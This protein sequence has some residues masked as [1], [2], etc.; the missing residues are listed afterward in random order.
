[1]ERRR[2]F[3][4]RCTRCVMP[5]KYPDISFNSEGVC[6]YC[7][8]EQHFGV[9]GDPE[10]RELMARKNELR[11]DFERA[12]SECKGQG[13]YDCLV[14]L[15]GGKDS[16]YLAYLLKERYE[17]KILSLTVDTGLL[18]KLAIPNCQKTAEY[19]DIDH[20]VITPRAGFFKKLYR[21][22]LTHPNFVKEKYEEVGYL[23]TVCRACCEAVHSIGLQEAYRRGIPLVALGYSPDQIEHYFYEIPRKEICEQ[24]WVPKELYN[25]PFDEEDRKYFWDPNIYT[26]KSNFPRVLLPYHVIDYSGIGDVTKKVEEIGLIRKR[27]ASPIVTNC[28]M[29][30]LLAYLDIKKQ[31]YNPIISALGYDIKEG[32]L[33]RTRRLIIG[34]EAVNWLMKSDVIRVFANGKMRRLLRQLDVKMDDLI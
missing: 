21:Y 8:G 5:E 13:E 16:A 4:K 15:S 24:G 28:Q 33:N 29:G 32:M 19:L 14:L 1:M 18:S 9:S 20:I 34:I 22:Y 27:K 3:T 30:M 26:E 11:E 17:L 7:L 6:G 2:L 12:V 23:S 10:V 25:E 31:G